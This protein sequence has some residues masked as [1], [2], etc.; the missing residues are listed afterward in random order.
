MRF[1]AARSRPKK[2]GQ[3]IPKN[4]CRTTIAERM[5]E[6]LAELPFIGDQ[7]SRAAESHRRA[8]AG[9]TPT[10]TRLSRYAQLPGVQKAPRHEVA[11]SRAPAAQRGLWGF[12]VN[13]DLD[14]GSNT[15]R[16]RPGCVD[17]RD[18]EPA[19][20]R[21]IQTRPSRSRKTGQGPKP[22]H[23]SPARSTTPGPALSVRT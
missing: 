9:R 19:R 16:K 7:V 22:A 18:G 13:A 4:R 3:N 10:I 2:S 20:G 8:L 11:G 17:R 1:L 21:V 15:A 6:T 14:A 12:D 23:R 5:V